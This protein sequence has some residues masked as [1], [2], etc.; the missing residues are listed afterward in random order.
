[1]KK[2]NRCGEIKSHNEFNK[3]RKTGIQAYCKPCQNEYGREHYH[4]DREANAEKQRLAKVARMNGIKHDVRKLK[5]ETPCA[6]CGMKYPYY[7]LDFDHIN[8]KKTTHISEMIAQGNARWRIFSEI[9]K[10]Q[11]VCAN[12]HRKRT[13]ERSQLIRESEY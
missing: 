3:K 4:K 6:D 1:M 12:C 7:V 8:G 13:H 9:A 2:C 10:C 11:V 5:E